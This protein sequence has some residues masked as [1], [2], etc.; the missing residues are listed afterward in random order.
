MQIRKKSSPFSRHSTFFYWKIVIVY[1]FHSTRRFV[2]SGQKIVALD[3]HIYDVCEVSEAPLN[4]A[5]CAVRHMHPE[6]PLI[7]TVLYI[8]TSFHKWSTLFFTIVC[9]IGKY[10]Y[11]NF[12]D[13]ATEVQG[14][15]KPFWTLT[16]ISYR[17]YLFN[18]ISFMIVSECLYDFGQVIDKNVYKLKPVGE[19][20][21]IYWV[22]TWCLQLYLI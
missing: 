11:L 15:G 21:R 8:L 17:S 7:Y 18:I 3:I 6:W 5:L 12:I 20:R 10:N 9:K 22:T 13:E 14:S 1:Q 4:A 19:S 2:A 16:F